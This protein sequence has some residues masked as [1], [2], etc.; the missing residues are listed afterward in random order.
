[1]AGLMTTSAI[2]LVLL[3][4]F[5]IHYSRSN[6]LIEGFKLQYYKCK[7]YGNT[8]VIQD[9]FDK[10]QIERSY[11]SKKWDLY[12]PCG[13]NYVEKELT[14]VHPTLTHQKIFGIN[15]CDRIV[16]K[17]GLWDILEKTYGRDIAKRLMPESF[18]LYSPK[19]MDL[20][21][22]SFVPNK[23][24]LLKKNIQRKQGI[25][26]TKNLNE[27]LSKRDSDFRVVQEYATNLYLIKNRKV[28][29]RVYMLIVCKNGQVKV[30]LHRYGKCIYTN[31]DYTDDNLDLEQHLTSLNLNQKVYQNR[32]QTFQQLKEYLGE[33]EFQRLMDNMVKNLI[34]VMRAS[35]QYLCRL[36]HLD[37]HVSF[38]LFG[39]DY[40]FTK[41]MYP[42]LLEMNKGPDMSLKNEEDNYLKNKVTEDLFQTANIFDMP[43]TTD[44]FQ[45]KL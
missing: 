44:F 27:I 28:N 26:L 20:F 17:N 4:I 36:K 40:I 1:M 25:V 22:K 3:I 19:D 34:M 45:L 15:G 13:Y 16:S 43:Q 18:I 33:N 12:V 37:Q 23:I 10:N 21:V 24:Y 30:Y 5:S 9:F 29:L 39:L 11:N 42:Y 32:P 38:Q 35:K 31:K 2:I 41:N 14:K 7:K 8:K 6:Q